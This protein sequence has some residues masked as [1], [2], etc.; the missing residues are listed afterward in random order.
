MRSKRF[1]MI[2][3]ALV[4]LI[5]VVSWP[6]TARAQWTSV[7]GAPNASTCLLLTDGSVIC[8]EGE[9]A[10]TWRRL[11]PDQNGHYDTGSWT[12]AGNLPAGYGP[13]Y[14]ASAVLAD[15]RVLMIGGEYNTGTPNCPSNPGCEV[16]LGAIYDPATN[17]WTAVTAPTGWTQI[18]DSDSFVLPD[19][20]FILRQFNSKAIAR[21][22]P[23][24]NDFTILNATGKADNH[25]EESSTLLPNGTVLVV[26]AGTQGGTNSEIFDPAG[27]GGQGAWSTAGSTQVSLPSNGGMGIVPEM[28]PQVLRPDGTVVAFGATSHNAIYNTASGLWTATNDYPVN[29]VQQL[30]FDAPGAMLPNGNILVATSGPFA[31]PYHVYEFRAAPNNDFVGVTDPSGNGVASFRVRMLVLPT[32]Q[33]M[34]TQGSSTVLLYTPGGTFED[35]WRPIITAG[36]KS[37][38]PGNS[39]TISGRQ[40]NGLSAGGA[41]GDD[42]QQSTNY[43]IVRIVNRGTGHVFYAKTHNHS[44]M[45]VQT[46]SLIVSTQFDVPTNLESGVSD[47]YVVANGIPSAPW[48]VNGPGLTLTGP[49]NLESCVGST[50]TAILNVCNTGKEDLSINNIT[51]S[52]AQFHVDDPGFSLVISPDFCFP[53]QAH[54]TPASP[55]P[56]A[57]LSATFSIAS[58]DPNMPVASEPVIGMSAPPTINIVEVNG[59]AFPNTCPGSFSDAPVLFVTNSSQCPLNITG[60]TSIGPNAA[61][62]T[63]PTVNP[64]PEF[65][66]VVPQH[67]T[68]Q[69]PIRFQEPMPATLATV[70]P[71]TPRTAT[72]RIAS[73]DPAHA[74]VDSPVSGFVPAPQLNATIAAGGNF[75]NVCSGNQGDLNLT[76]VN[77]GQ[78]NLNV[79]AITKNGNFVQP[80]VTL[81]LILSHDASVNLPIR[82]TPTGVCSDSIPQTGNIQI[83]SNNPGGTFIQSLSG[84]EGCPKIVLSPANLTG[85]FAFPP[86]VSDPTNNL[87]CYT[88]RQITVSNAGS[89]PLTITNAVAAPSNT[90]NVVN[91]QM[92]LTIG[93][94]AGPVPI[95]VRFKP[96]I[97]AGQLNNAPDQQTGLLTLFSND[98]VAPLANLC[99]EPTTRSGFRLLVTDGTMTPLAS[100]SAITLSSKGLSPQFSQKITDATP[101]LAA[102]C[103]NP[104]GSIKYHWDNETLPPAGTTGANPKASYTLDIKAAGKPISQSFTLGQCEFKTL[105]L[106]YK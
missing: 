82:F 92:P 90:F 15:G 86:T 11:T 63:T 59:G 69:L 95:T 76:L 101:V 85:L 12:S 65:P 24:T 21:F 104:A 4:A 19:G 42:D 79:T 39:Y 99:G 32:G 75:G 103:Q 7:A 52:N 60:I 10:N 14:Y 64:A 66:L 2:L 16:N 49:L 20:T 38:D 46:G 9:E 87:G 94:G 81:P 56:P 33:V 61:N 8:Q 45:G 100:V 67:S 13:L 29:G 35:S 97:L 44:S 77:Q 26:D 102:L 37:I 5:V 50:A 47:L 89:C 30:M 1:Q 28:G 98:P 57:G 3:R 70:V 83:V 96:T 36:P 78:C 68:V 55:T 74:T 40:F 18:G 23:A 48:V 17:L 58:N 25:S 106:Q 62:F 34:V 27:N 72:I 6:L 73:N 43:P 41:Y 54:F 31:G 53:F 93:P 91:P 71:P 22:N 88:D 51:S 105:T 80:T 84:I